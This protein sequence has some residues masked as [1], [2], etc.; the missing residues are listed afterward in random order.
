MDQTAL[1]QL[2]IE[3]EETGT[4]SFDL[5]GVPILN[6]PPPHLTIS[7]LKMAGYPVDIG[8]G[9][10]KNRSGQ[11]I[12]AKART[13]IAK[14]FICHYISECIKKDNAAFPVLLMI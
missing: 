8:G 11:P 13:I 4:V 14:H 9:N 7:E 12:A 10:K 5:E 1:V 3:Q 6:K 2:S